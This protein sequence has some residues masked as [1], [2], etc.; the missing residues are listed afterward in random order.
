MIEAL[1]YVKKFPRAV[2]PLSSRMQH[3]Y[4]NTAT[5]RKNIGRSLL[6]KYGQV[7]SLALDPIEKKPCTGL[8][9]KAYLV[10]RDVRLQYELPFCQNHRI[11]RTRPI[12]N[13]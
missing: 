5:V 3:R 10:A 7:S 2:H 1:Y 11:S 9:R 12:R 13:R 6:G 8:S 4:G